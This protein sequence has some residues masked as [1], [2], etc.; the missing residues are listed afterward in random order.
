[1]MGNP[2]Y[3][4]GQTSENDANKNLRY[5]QLD[6]AIR[7][8]YVEN[9]TATL[10]NSL[11]D[12]YIRAFRWASDRIGKSGIV[13][14]VSNGSFIDGNAMDG[15]RKCLTDEFTSIYSFNL[16]GNQRTSGELSRKEGGKIFG[17]GSRAS[18]AITLLVKNADKKEKCDL[19]YYDIGD[20]LTR[21]QKLKIISDFGSVK[22][23]KWQKITPN[24]SHDWINKRDPAFDSFIPIGDKQCTSENGVFEVYSNGLKTNR[25]AWIYNFSSNSLSDNLIKMI[26]FYN[27]QLKRYK[28][29]KNKMPQGK[30]LSIEE[31]IDNNPQNISW[32]VNLKN[33]LDKFIAH[34]YKKGSITRVLYRPYCK[35]WG[36]F[37]SD[38][39]ERM[40]QMPLLFPEGKGD[41]L[42]ICV[43]GRG[44]TKEFSALIVNTLPDYEFISKGQCFPIKV[45]NTAGENNS[46][47]KL[48][49]DSEN[50]LGTEDGISNPTIKIFRDF[51]ANQKISKE[52]IFYYVYGI[53]HSPEYKNRFESDLKKML[54]RIPFAEDF[55]AFSKAGRALAK[56][57]LNYE[58]VEP[59]PLKQHNDK[60]ELFPKD[61]Y[62]VQK[63]I[64]REKCKGSR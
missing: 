31:I 55:W 5:P 43:T 11:Y 20:Y 19:H 56:W 63:M 51:Y 25:D 45:F 60:L 9:S 64:F 18:I 2:P 1:M 15:F 34:E 28:T 47:L 48:N 13:C 54:P 7:N 4:A 6:K 58:T 41:N 40:G 46:V 32:S 24:E 23:I 37:N 57:H 21:E 52:D 26:N 49:L 3:S 44:A 50:K 8:T 16:R 61:F 30:K 22:N 10:K 42:V 36:Y 12:S 59:Y 14:Y 38:F 29:Y 62:R 27:E 35:Q 17:S 53:L 39:I 33:D